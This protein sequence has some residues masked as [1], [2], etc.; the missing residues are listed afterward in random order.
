MSSFI[1]GK[2]RKRGVHTS[3]RSDGTPLD[4]LRED[5]Q[6]LRTDNISIRILARVEGASF[7][8]ETMESVMTRQ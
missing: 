3:N 1:S 6:P 5:P 8:W 7:M 4:D 2:A